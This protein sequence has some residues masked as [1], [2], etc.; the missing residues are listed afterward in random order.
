MDEY[1]FLEGSEAY[2]YRFASE[3][4]GLDTIAIPRSLRGRAAVLAATTLGRGGIF[5]ALGRRV[6]G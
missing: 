2:K 6:A 4:E 3:D 1:R 5:A